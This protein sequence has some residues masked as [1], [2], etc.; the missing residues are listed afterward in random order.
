[1]WFIILVIVLIYALLLT[2]IQQGIN[3]VIK[4]RR[5]NFLANFL[6]AIVL[7]LLLY[8]VTKSYGYNLWE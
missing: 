1:M 2:P 3:R 7:F 5:L 6:L 8:A 4:D